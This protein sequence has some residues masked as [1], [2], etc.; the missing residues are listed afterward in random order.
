MWKFTRIVLS[1]PTLLIAGAL[2]GVLAYFTS[3]E[4]LARIATVSSMGMCFMIFMAGFCAARCIDEFGNR[5]LGQR[6]PWYTNA[7]G[8]AYLV[9]A[10]VLLATVSYHVCTFV[11]FAIG[12]AG[13]TRWGVVFALQAMTLLVLAFTIGAQGSSADQGYIPPRDNDHDDSPPDFLPPIVP[14]K[15]FR[16]RTHSDD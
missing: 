12:R 16:H 15:S 1:L 4:F 7:A 8:A 6:G 9:V 10:M 13:I 11:A 14:P 2:C 5:M 3:P